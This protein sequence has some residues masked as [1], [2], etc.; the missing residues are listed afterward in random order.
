MPIQI[1]SWFIHV[2][3]IQSSVET[4][5]PQMTNCSTFFGHAR[6]EVR[7]HRLWNVTAEK[8]YHPC[9]VDDRWV[10]PEMVYPQQ[11]IRL[12]SV[13]SYLKLPGYQI[14]WKWCSYVTPK[15]QVG[16]SDDHAKVPMNIKTTLGLDR[17]WTKSRLTPNPKDSKDSYV[18]KFGAGGVHHE[19]VVWLDSKG[20]HQAG[21]P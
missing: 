11:I 3:P 18:W 7:L 2:Y 20:E 12:S 4:N 5:I 17:M 8:S 6:L 1:V 14:I 15:F 16:W 19:K 13:P 9:A 10:Y 21:K